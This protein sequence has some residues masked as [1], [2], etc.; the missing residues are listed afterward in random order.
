VAMTMPAAAIKSAAST[1][2]AVGT[3]ATISTAAAIPAAA[4]EWPLEAGTSTAADASGVAGRKFL[5]RAGMGGASF[6]GKEDLF[7]AGA[8]PSGRNSLR[9]SFVGMLF[10]VMIEVLFLVFFAILFFVFG[11][12]MFEFDVAEGRD[13]QRVFVR[14]ICSSFRDGLRSA[15]DFLN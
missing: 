8:G 15:Y 10:G 7:F 9:F 5:S 13:V 12:V 4:T 3:P 14:G 11:L 2:A 6:A 1:A